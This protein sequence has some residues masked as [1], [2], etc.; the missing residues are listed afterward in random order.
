M[1]VKTG[2]RLHLGLIDLNGDIGRKDGGVGLSI[3]NPGVTINIDDAEKLRV[4]GP[5]CSIVKDHARTVLDYFDIDP[6]AL[7]I[8]STIPRHAGLGSGTQLALATA[9]AITAYSGI[10]LPTRKLSHI[11]GR[12]G[13]SGIGTYAFDRGGFIVDGGHSGDDKEQFLPSSASDA[14]PPPLTA[15]MEF[16]DW[17]IK[18]FLPKGSGT[19]GTNEESLFVKETPIPINQVRKVS[20]TILMKLMPAVREENFREF[21]QAIDSLQSMGWKAMEVQKQ[22]KSRDI[23]NKLSSQGVAAGLSSWGPAVFAVFP[24]RINSTEIDC[25]VINVDIDNSGAK[26]LNEE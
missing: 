7:E 20:H 11:V 25:E 21:K 14:P 9:K 1:R 4:N 23:I 6:V 8:E 3:N 2:S 10:E 22:P 15:R 17:N 19:H 13:T 16:P 26:V 5:E 18:I 12:G 24:T